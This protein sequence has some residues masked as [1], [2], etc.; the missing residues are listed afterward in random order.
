LNT[1][2][3]PIFMNFNYFG[4]RA[5]S[6]LVYMIHR[7]QLNFGLAYLL[8]FVPVCFVFSKG[9]STQLNV[10]YIL[11]SDLRIDPE[12]AQDYIIPVKLLDSMIMDV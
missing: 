10:L 4:T 8:R 2:S 9:C 6:D 1:V 7:T 12:L 3:L 11:T 5:G